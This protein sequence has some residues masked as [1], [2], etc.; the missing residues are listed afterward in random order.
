MTI[1]ISLFTT[2]VGIHIF[3]SAAF[4]S[5]EKAIQEAAYRA[6][7][8]FHF[9]HDHPLPLAA[10]VSTLVALGAKTDVLKAAGFDV[11]SPNAYHTRVERESLLAEWLIIVERLSQ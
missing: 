5:S 10:F 7:Y 9:D 8:A 1:T 2:I 3:A 4:T 11:R 6:L